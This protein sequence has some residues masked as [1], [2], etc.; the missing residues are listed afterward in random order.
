MKVKSFHRFIIT[1][2]NED[3]MP[4]KA[5]D[6][7]NIIIRSSDELIGNTE[8]FTKIYNYIDDV[9]AV[10]SI[11]EY[12]KSIPDL[13]N[14]HKEKMPMTEYQEDLQEMNANPIEL[15]VKYYIKQNCSNGEFKIKTSDLYDNFNSYL[16]V[17]FSSWNVNFL[18]FSC[19]LK[20][21]NVD[22]IDK[23]RSNSTRFTKFNIDKCLEHFGLDKTEC[24][25]EVEE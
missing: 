5:G 13:D 11:F 20:R 8:H 9:D 2:N 16:K 7:R 10:K 15:W 3:P 22:G 4:T 25:V 19:R 21:L 18:Q 14:F 6:R 23:S 24:L 17:Y 1:T 12:F